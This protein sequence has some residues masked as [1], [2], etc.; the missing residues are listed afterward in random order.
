MF[1]RVK[2]FLL[3]GAILMVCGAVTAQQYN[4][5]EAEGEG[6]IMALNFGNNSMVVGGYDYQ[7]SESVQVQINGSY[8]AFT[9]LEEEMLIEFTYQRF[10][11]GV[12]RIGSGDGA[13]D[14]G[15]PGQCR[16]R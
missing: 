15:V 13:T 14:L 4:P 11:D 6:R 2:Q 16:G 9:M 10:D 8:G 7:V 1:K 5:P 12:R 3:G